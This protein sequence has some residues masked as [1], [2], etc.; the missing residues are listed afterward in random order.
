MGTERSNEDQERSQ[1]TGREMDWVRGCSING[2]GTGDDRGH[3]VTQHLPAVQGDLAGPG[4]GITRVKRSPE[5]NGH[6]NS[7]F[8]RFNSALQ[9]P[10]VPQ[11]QFLE[12]S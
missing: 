7:E 11:C 6:L 4:K 9:F 10:K 8:P 1:G 5:V 2:A 3:D 12:G